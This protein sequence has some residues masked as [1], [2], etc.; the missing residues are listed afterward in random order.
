MF[1]DKEFME[2]LLDK[3]TLSERLRQ[4]YDLR[5]SA[6]DTSQRMLNAL[7]P[8][9]V[10]PIHNH[11]DTAETVICLCGKLEEIF[12]GHLMPVTKSLKRYQDIFFAPMRGNM[13]CRY[14]QEFGIVSM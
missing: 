6:F 9:T 4:N 8:G 3:A 14:R 11:I 2:Q 7:Q 13:V 12:Y 5:N 10:V 1:F